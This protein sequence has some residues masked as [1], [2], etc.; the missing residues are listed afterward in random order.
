MAPRH[1]GCQRG[2]L[3]TFCPF[4]HSRLLYRQRTLSGNRTAHDRP[5]LRSGIGRIRSHGCRQLELAGN[6]PLVR[7]NRSG[8]RFCTHIPAPRKERIRQQG[9]Y[10]AESFSAGKERDSHTVV[11]SGVLQHRILGDTLLLRN[12]IGAGMG[13][14]ELA[15]DSFSR[16][17]RS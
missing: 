9:A 3:H 6:I 16:Q 12:N 4:S 10:R 2:A 17:P 8:I 5:L 14:K 7:N 11:C 1:N 15:A 13:Y